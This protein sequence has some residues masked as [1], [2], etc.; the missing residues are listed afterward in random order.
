M[1]LKISQIYCQF[2][3]GALPVADRKEVVEK[4][5]CTSKFLCDISR[6]TFM[7]NPTSLLHVKVMQSIKLIG[8]R[9]VPAIRKAFDSR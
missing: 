9:V 4:I 2:A 8:T 7:L 6:I 5:T 3:Q 1:N